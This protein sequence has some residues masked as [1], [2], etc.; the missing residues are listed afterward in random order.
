MASHALAD[1]E[2]ITIA[3]QQAYTEGLGFDRIMAV[4][5][6]LFICGLFLDGWAHNHHFVDNTFFTPWHA[7]LYSAFAGNALALAIATFRNH[8]RG[9]SWLAAIP[10]GYELAVIGIPLFI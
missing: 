3:K 1:G 9:R 7:I 6:L 8:A 2:N 5:G 4:L 10:R